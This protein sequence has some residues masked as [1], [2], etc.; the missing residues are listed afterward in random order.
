MF[1]FSS[2]LAQRQFTAADFT[3]DA[4]NHPGATDNFRTALSVE[5]PL[6]DRAAAARVRT[7][8]IGRDIAATGRPASY[9][10]DVDAI[11]GHL[12]AATVP[13]DVVCVFSNG[14][15]G[16]IHAKLLA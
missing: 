16:G 1:V 12:R 15:F 8:S 6:F 2:L 14:G 4:I 13:G 7:A 11:V 10:P 5:Q 3:V 9:L